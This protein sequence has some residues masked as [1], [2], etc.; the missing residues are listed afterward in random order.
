MLERILEVEA[1]D[2]ELE[3]LDYDSMDHS[4]VNRAFVSDLI[5]WLERLG[6]EELYLLD[7]GT[8]TALIPI[9]LCSRFD[10]CSVR[11]VDLAI[12]MLKIG[13]RNVGAAG[14][15]D[16]IILQ[17]ED[18]KR[19][20]FPDDQFDAVVSNSIIHHIPEP[21]K[22]LAEIKRVLRPGGVFF[23]R[24]LCRPDSLERVDEII[25]TYAG[26]E[27][28]HQQQMFRDSLHAALTVDDVR[29]MLRT[30]SLPEEWATM[31]SDRHWTIA[32]SK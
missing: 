13:H 1:M 31:T 10:R 8:G 18:A 26:E 21:L 16:R 15:T 17:Q 24:D 25:K 19:F 28:A 14:L 27:N 9:E 2:T 32:G 7:V 3:A 30:I 12:E 22:A 5:P 29:E 4:H 23:V 6:D 11:A 20:S